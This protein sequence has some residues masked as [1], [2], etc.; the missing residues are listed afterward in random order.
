MKNNSLI[1]TVAATAGIFFIAGAIGQ[2]PQMKDLGLGMLIATSLVKQHSTDK[3]LSNCAVNQLTPWQQ[4]NLTSVTNL[5]RSLENVERELA[6]VVDRNS[7]IEKLERASKLVHKL[8]KRLSN[9]EKQQNKIRS[10]VDQL[11]HKVKTQE[12]SDKQ[13]R[14]SEQKFTG[15]TKPTKIT[16]QLMAQQPTTHIYID[17]NNFKCATHRLNM[18]ID[19]RALK[20]YLMPNNGKIRLN[21]YDGVCPSSKF[22][23]NRFHS[24]L[25]QI[26]YTVITLPKKTYQDGTYKTVGDDISIAIDIL[27][28]VKSGDRLILLSGDGDFFPVIKKIQQRQVKVTAIASRASISELTLHKADEFICLEELQKLISTNDNSKAA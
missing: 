22:K 10:L 17:G 12:E 7:D 3:K 8:E 21:F 19:Y 28:R 20:S 4:N 9:Q 13:S 25:R 24:Y 16:S 15:L 5:S 23:Q 11:K 18:T 2:K 1:N 6:K 26:G 27:D 14:S